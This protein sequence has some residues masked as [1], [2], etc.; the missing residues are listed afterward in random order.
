[1]A[2]DATGLG[3]D[4]AR[5]SH[6]EQSSGPRVFTN[7]RA[8]AG[9]IFSASEPCCPVARQIQVADYRLRSAPHTMLR[10]GRLPAKLADP[11]GQMLHAP[12]SPSGI[13]AMSPSPFRAI[14]PETRRWP[15]SRSFP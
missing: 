14:L 9:R 8:G 12:Y 3:M 15:A 7:C 11:L 13:V 1:M 10:R 6:G 4:K 2:E 5:Q